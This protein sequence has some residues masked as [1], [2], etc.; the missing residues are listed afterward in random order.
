[1]PIAAAFEQRSTDFCRRFLAYSLPA[2]RSTLLP[3]FIMKIEFQLQSLVIFLNI[4]DF[5]EFPSK[6][7]ILREFQK[8]PSSS[9]PSPFPL[10]CSAL[11]APHLE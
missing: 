8:R 4:L 11:S 2:V 10:S 7:R 5:Q 1:M 3:P 6:F 9:S